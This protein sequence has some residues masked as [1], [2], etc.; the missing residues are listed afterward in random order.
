MNGCIL[1]DTTGFP[2][3]DFG[4][5]VSNFPANVVEVNWKILEAIPSQAPSPKL[6]RTR[7]DLIQPQSPATSFI[8][9]CPVFCGQTNPTRAS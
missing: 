3:G 8:A 5:E 6:T 9:S 4:L 7:P 2:E 1:H